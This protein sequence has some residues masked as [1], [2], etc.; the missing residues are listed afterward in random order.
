MFSMSSMLEVS[1]KEAS[2]QLLFPLFLRKRE[3]KDFRSSGKVGGIYKIIFKILANKL[4]LVL[5]R[6]ISKTHNV[7]IK[8]KALSLQMASQ[9]RKLSYNLLK[10]PISSSN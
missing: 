8:R 9:F 4:K 1:L 3:I 6:V 2:I 7:T 5:E 10:N